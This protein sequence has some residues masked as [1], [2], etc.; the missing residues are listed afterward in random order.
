M[1]FGGE[2]GAT[3]FQPGLE[4]LETADLF[5]ALLLR[6]QLQESI[7]GDQILLAFEDVLEVFAIQLQI[8]EGGAHQNTLCLGQGESSQ[9]A[10]H[11]IELGHRQVHLDP[12]RRPQ[13]PEGPNHQL[14]EFPDR[15]KL[16]VDQRG[17][18]LQIGRDRNLRTAQDESAPVA[19]ERGS[20]IT[21]CPENLRVLEVL[22]EVVKR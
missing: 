8:V 9:L 22:L 12:L 1:C 10:H 14:L 5:Q 17:A 2:G 21:E 13:A 6:E 20:N 16:H 11:L 18:S 15:G 7:A 3:S 19:T 4:V